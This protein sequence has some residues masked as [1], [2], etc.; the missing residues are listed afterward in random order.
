[1]KEQNRYPSFLRCVRIWR[2][3]KLL[4][5]AGRGH[6]EDGVSRIERG[7]LCIRCPACPCPGFNIPDNWESVS[8]DLR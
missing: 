2:Y 4:K 3:L 8:E 7:D 5:R 6:I 1:M